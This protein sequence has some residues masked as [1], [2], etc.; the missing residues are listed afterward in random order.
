MFASKFTEAEAL[1]ASVSR[2]LG[3]QIID[4]GYRLTA[5]CFTARSQASA[6]RKTSVAGSMCMRRPRR[7]AFLHRHLVPRRRFDAGR[8]LRPLPLRNRGIAVVRSANY[9]LSPGV[10]SPAFIE[11]AAAAIA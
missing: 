10:K 9:L 1:L 6:P 2:E 4:G 11:D 3:K 7:E 5:D 8:A